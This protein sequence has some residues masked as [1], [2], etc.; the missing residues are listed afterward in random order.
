MED[1]RHKKLGELNIDHEALLYLPK[2]KHTLK[3]MCL[4]NNLHGEIILDSEEMYR[5]QK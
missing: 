3:Y 2:Y 4:F 1:E 5:I